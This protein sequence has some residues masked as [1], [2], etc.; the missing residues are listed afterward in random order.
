MKI[1]SIVSILFILISCRAKENA[2]ADVAVKK[3]NEK[4]LV[5][6]VAKIGQKEEVFETLNIQKVTMVDSKMLVDLTYLGNCDTIRFKAI[7]LEYEANEINPVRRILL[8]QPKMK[9]TCIAEKNVTFEIDL[10]QILIN[11]TVGARNVFILDG[12]PDRFEYIV[13]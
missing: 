5:K 6:I 8:V 13:K 12:W 9:E 10:T 4:Q 7:G 11:K 1:L 3:T 2:T